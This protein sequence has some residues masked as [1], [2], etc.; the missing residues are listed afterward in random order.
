MEELLA[1]FAKD[2]MRVLY[3][4]GSSGGIVFWWD[5]WRHRP[6]L[7]LRVRDHG[8]LQ[9]SPGLVLS[10]ENLGATPTSLEPAVT[11]Q[12]LRW[13]DGERRWRPLVKRRRLYRLTHPDLGL[14]V[15]DRRTLEAKPVGA[16]ES[17][18]PVM[19]QVTVR[20]RR[21]RVRFFTTRR[22]GLAQWWW[23]RLRLFARWI[24][25]PKSPHTESEAAAHRLENDL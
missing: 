9:Q 24:P 14:P 10:V 11:V 19:H 25:D 18:V 7:R 13:A 4:L 23:Y 6:H 20:G 2:P 17:I 22:V 12:W 15:H 8:V 5:R 1:Y 16:W 21:A 3:L